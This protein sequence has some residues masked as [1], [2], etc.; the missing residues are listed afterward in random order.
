MLKRAFDILASGMA[1]V[2][3]APLFL[4]LAVWVRTDSRGPILS[5]QVRVGRRRKEFTLL[6]FRT[7]VPTANGLGLAM[8]VEDR[9]PR[10]TR[11]GFVLRKLGLDG[12][13][14]LVNVFLGHMSMVGPRPEVPRFVQTYDRSML[15]ALDERPGL[16]DPALIA[17]NRPVPVVVAGAESE[18]AYL[19]RVVPERLTLNRIH[20]ES[21]SSVADMW[22]ALR[23]GMRQIAKSLD[24]H[25]VQEGVRLRR[26]AMTGATVRIPALRGAL[27]AK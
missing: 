15:R 9:D 8:P 22:F 12:L 26:E 20:I 4:L 5:R 14:Q 16:F 3:L 7:L 27:G 23:C 18:R 2:L 19:E 1:L 21:S 17:L 11:L 24:V 25:A 6:K 13:P 10:L